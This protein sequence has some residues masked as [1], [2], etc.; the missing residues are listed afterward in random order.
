MKSAQAF[1]RV[2]VFV[3]SLVVLSAPRGILAQ[4]PSCGTY[5]FEYSACSGDPDCSSSYPFY[6]NIGSGQE[7]LQSA[8]ECQGSYCNP[9]ENEEPSLNPNEC[10]VDPGGICNLSSDCCVGTCVSNKCS[11]EGCTNSGYPCTSNSQ[12]CTAMCNQKTCACLTNGESCENSIN[13]CSQS[14]AGGLCV[15]QSNGG[16]CNANSQCCSGNCASGHCASNC[17][18]VHS[19]CY[20][21]SSC[22]NFCSNYSCSLACNGPPCCLASGTQCSPSGRWCCSGHCSASLGRCL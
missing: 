15:C 5:S 14:C 6:Y 18:P 11:S 8:Y 13:C 10:C 16:S 17:L 12:C 4:N 22:C 21:N 9:I 19:S 3:T 20:D 7:I 2:M 1:L